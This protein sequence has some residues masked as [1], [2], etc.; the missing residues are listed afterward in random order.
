[1]RRHPYAN[2]FIHFAIIV[3]AGLV[4]FHAD[5]RG[6]ITFRGAIV[7]PTCSTAPATEAGPTRCVTSPTTAT[8]VR[9]SR[10]LAHAASP[11][12]VRYLAS[13]TKQQPPIVTM[14]YD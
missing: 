2:P 9:V 8:S 13:Y 1:M 4:S 3:I 14:A 11:A 10:S 5:A 12:T 6:R 7:S